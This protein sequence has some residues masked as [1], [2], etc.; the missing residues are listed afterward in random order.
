MLMGYLAYKIGFPH[1][2]WA[3]VGGFTLGLG[4]AVMVQRHRNLRA[5][6]KSLEK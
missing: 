1:L 3:L 2:H 5:K 4:A 6:R